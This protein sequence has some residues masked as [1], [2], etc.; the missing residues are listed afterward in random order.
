MPAR[1]TTRG[2]GSAGPRCSGTR[3]RPG[4][5][6][7]LLPQSGVPLIYA[8]GG[9]R[10]VDRKPSHPFR[11]GANRAASVSNAAPRRTTANVSESR[12]RSAATRTTTPIATSSRSRC[13]FCTNFAL[14]ASS[15]AQSVLPTLL[16]PQRSVQAIRSVL[17]LRVLGFVFAAILIVNLIALLTG[18]LSQN[19]RLLL[20]AVGGVGLGLV[21]VLERRGRG[22]SSA[23]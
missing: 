9:L 8:E 11:F 19:T 22:D 17:M 10:G 3:G 5:R 12:R 18:A 23:A 20:L 7:P 15:L 14:P 4:G 21:A 6:P 1:T 13:C 2:I 16:L